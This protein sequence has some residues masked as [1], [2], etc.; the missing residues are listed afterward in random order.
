MVIT[1]CQEKGKQREGNSAD[2]AQNDVQRA[3]GKDA[4][5][6]RKHTDTGKNFQQNRVHVMFASFP[7]HHFT[8]NR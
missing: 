8:T 7:L 4:D 2:G 6:I 3:V 5:V 1:L